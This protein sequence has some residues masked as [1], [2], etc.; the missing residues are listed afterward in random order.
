MTLPLVL[1]AAVARNGVIGGDNKLL[2]RIPGDLKYFKRRTMGRPML[3]GRKTFESIG[4]PLPG[5]TSIVVTRDRSFSHEGGLVTHSLDEGIT[6][7]DRIGREQGAAEIAVI[8][9]AEIYRQI[10]DRASVLAL[11]EV[12]L[13]PEGDAFFPSFDRSE[14]REVFRE[15]HEKGPQDDAAHVF[16]DYERIAK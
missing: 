12:D 6:L 11:T 7:A 1:V 15:P 16:V 8:G 9:G 14:W 13:A 5:R 10:M 2:W 4:K 3:M